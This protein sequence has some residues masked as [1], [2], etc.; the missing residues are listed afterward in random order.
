MIPRLICFFKGHDIDEE[1]YQESQISSFWCPMG[2]LVK[3]RIKHFCNKCKKY[4]LWNKRKR[5]L[6]YMVV[7]DSIE[8]KESFEE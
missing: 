4:I 7:D 8:V 5:V 3:F 1:K 2:A 6:T